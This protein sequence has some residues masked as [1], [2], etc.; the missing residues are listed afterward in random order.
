VI[1]EVKELRTEAEIQGFPDRESLRDPEIPVVLARATDH[2]IGSVSE[3]CN[4]RNCES[5]GIEPICKRL[6]SGRVADEIGTL[7]A[8]SDSLIVRGE[9][10]GPWKALL[11]GGYACDLPS[12]KNGFARAML[13]VKEGKLPRVVEYQDVR[14][15]EARQAFVGPVVA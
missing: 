11:K 3:S 13:V 9:G 15:V 2:T 4:R 1:E 7:R 5:A 10:H 6:C 8:A 14:D 12:V